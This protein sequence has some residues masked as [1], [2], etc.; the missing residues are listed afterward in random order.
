[1]NVPI[2]LVLLLLA[3]TYSKLCLA[4]SIT[5]SQAKALLGSWQLDLQKSVIMA[6]AALDSA[7]KQVADSGEP[8]DQDALFN[9][10]AREKDFKAIDHYFNILHVDKETG[11]FYGYLAPD[12]LIHPLDHTVDSIIVDRYPTIARM[13]GMV[14]GIPG[15]NSSTLV[16]V[17]DVDTGEWYG[18]ID[19]NAQTRT[20][21]RIE[22]LKV[23]ATPSAEIPLDNQSTAFLYYTKDRNITAEQVIKDLAPCLPLKTNNNGVQYPSNAQRRMAGPMVLCAAALLLW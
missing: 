20:L 17:Q 11:I 7:I 5:E 15:T 3:L 23:Y 16:A 21:H 8:L 18:D 19:A 6:G 12:Y 13:L 2:T 14:T 9:S 10:I 1:M 22:G 4:A